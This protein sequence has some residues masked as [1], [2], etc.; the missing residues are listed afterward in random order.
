[1]GRPRRHTAARFTLINGEAPVQRAAGL[2]RSEHLG[3]MGATGPLAEEFNSLSHE[4]LEEWN[5]LA[6]A[7]PGALRQFS[8]WMVMWLR[9]SPDGRRCVIQQLE[10]QIERESK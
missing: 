5:R 2:C 9:L 6:R 1:M 10:R 3:E 7:N 8:E 4:E